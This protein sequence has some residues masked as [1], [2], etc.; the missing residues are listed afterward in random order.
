MAA[1]LVQRGEIAAKALLELPELGLVIKIA[2]GATGQLGLFTTR[3]RKASELIYTE[4]TSM[5]GEFGV[6]GKK[7]EEA[8]PPPISE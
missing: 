1:T 7:T 5:V 6:A 8:V 3:S 4:D 2:D